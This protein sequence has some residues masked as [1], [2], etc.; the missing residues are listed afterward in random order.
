MHSSN[1]IGFEHSGFVQVLKFSMLSSFKLKNASLLILHWLPVF[2]CVDSKRRISLCFL[3]LP[4]NKDSK[5]D[6]RSS[7]LSGG[8]VSSY[9]DKAGDTH[10]IIKV[11][12]FP[13]RESFNNLVS[14]ESLNIPRASSD[15]L[16]LDPSLNLIPLLEDALSEPARST[17]D[18]DSALASVGCC[19]RLSL[20]LRSISISSSTL[21]TIFIVIPATDVVF[22]HSRKNKEFC[23]SL[24]FSYKS[25]IVKYFVSLP[26]MN[27]EVQK[28]DENH[29]LL[30]YVV[31]LKY[32]WGFV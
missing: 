24:T 3:I 25:F 29:I 7:K 19:V 16:M 10:E 18:N 31:F 30:I 5:V 2:F 20:P 15:L 11:L 23:C 8:N 22:P 32:L 9:D 12:Q 4:T 14:F 28:H 21:F 17:M 1:F 6:L 13:P 27:F 26:S